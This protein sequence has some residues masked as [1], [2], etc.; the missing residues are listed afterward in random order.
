MPT[1]SS[2]APTAPIPVVHLISSFQVGGAEKLV[3]DFLLATKG[4]R[5]FINHL[6]V[7]NDRID[8]GLGAIIEQNNIPHVFFRRPPGS[9][10]VAFLWHFVRRLHAVRPQ[11]LHVHS[12]FTLMLALVYK[13]LHPTVRIVSTVHAMASL[14]VLPWHRRLAFRLFTVANIAIS[15]SVR[16]D[17]VRVGMPNVVR[18]Y[19]GINL[20]RFRGAPHPLPAS[21]AT[22]ATVISVGRLV[23]AIKGQDVL[24]RAIARARQ[25]GHN[26]RLRLVGTPTAGDS[27]TEPALKDLARELGMADAV[28]FMGER[29]D[30][31]EQLA[32]A[33]I[34]VMASLSEGFGLTLIEAMAA[35]LPV[36]SS[37]IAG[38]LEILEN[39][40]YGLT[41]P[42]GDPEALAEALCHLLADPQ[43]AFR[44][45]EQGLR[46]AEVFS[47][48]AMSADY[49]RLYG[50]VLGLTLP[51]EP[52]ASTDRRPLSGSHSGPT[53][54]PTSGQSKNKHKSQLKNQSSRG[55]VKSRLRAARRRSGSALGSDS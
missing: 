3:T 26:L 47:I 5:S 23:P 25:S 9:K 35:G 20:R 45:A 51:A 27:Q 37:A 36:I 44:H 39:G 2:V 12:S 54:G 52:L 38:P 21:S 50:D 19:N 40:A 42:A 13:A 49:L 22:A 11:I 41:V 28:E 4:N 34:F 14:L 15:E 10:N 17:A 1:S 55:K 43:E 8:P 30:I 7:I 46:R 48:E 33:D 31:P 53:S 29:Q 6:W 18:I 32:A 16:A 24:I